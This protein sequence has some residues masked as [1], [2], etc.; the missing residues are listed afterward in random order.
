MVG[1][2]TNSVREVGDPTHPVFL[3]LSIYRELI[4]SEDYCLPNDE[5]ENDRL[6]IHNHMVNILLGGRLHLAP[7]PHN[8][9]RILDLGTGEART[10]DL[11]CYC[12]ADLL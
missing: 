10:S 2:I 12:V 8:C 9:Q 6:D 7:I 1:G 4:Q 3:L 5:L 11:W